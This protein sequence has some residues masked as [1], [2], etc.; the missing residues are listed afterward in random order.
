[1]SNIDG[2]LGKSIPVHRLEP[3]VRNFQ[4]KILISVGDRQLELADVAAY[5]FQQIDDESSIE[6]IS[7]R[8]SLEYGIPSDMALSDVTELLVELS[9]ARLIDLS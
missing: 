5:I 4:E 2:K 8:V 6:W 1:M 3:R 7:E 9:A